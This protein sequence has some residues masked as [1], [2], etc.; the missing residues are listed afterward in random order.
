[1]LDLAYIASVS[2]ILVMAGAV[3]HTEYTLK[4]NQPGRKL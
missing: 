4:H 2:V 3:L 1:V